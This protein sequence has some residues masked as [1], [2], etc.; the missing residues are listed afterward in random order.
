[1]PPQQIQSPKDKRLFYSCYFL[2]RDASIKIFLFFWL[3]KVCTWSNRQSFF[4]QIQSSID[5]S[6]FQP[7][8]YL[9]LSAPVIGL[10]TNQRTLPPIMGLAYLVFSLSFNLRKNMCAPTEIRTPNLN[11]SSS[12][13]NQLKKFFVVRTCFLF[14]FFKGKCNAKN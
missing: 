3:G 8:S 10:F 4:S 1:M 12:S 2:R 6:M 9:G 7:N 5:R 11:V 13:S 14:H